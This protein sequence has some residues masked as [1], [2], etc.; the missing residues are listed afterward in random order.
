MVNQW[1]WEL[2]TCYVL[3]R[4][5][6]GLTSGFL[7][8]AALAAPSIPGDKNS[9]SKW[10]KLSTGW[11]IWLAPYALY[12]FCDPIMRLLWTLVCWEIPNFSNM[13]M[14]AWFDSHC[15]DSDEASFRDWKRRLGQNFCRVLCLMQP[16]HCPHFKE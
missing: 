16:G 3:W 9:P 13:T 14:T 2:L 1:F 5:A 11:K 15:L 8:Y 12:Y 6:R 4:L 7:I 10:T